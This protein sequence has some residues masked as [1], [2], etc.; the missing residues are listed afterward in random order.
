MSNTV[1]ENFVADFER[2]GSPAWLQ[3]GRDAALAAFRAGGFPTLRQE[4]WKYTDVRPIAGRSFRR[5][6]VPGS[7]DALVAAQRLGSDAARELVFVDGHCTTTEGQPPIPGARVQSLSRALAETPAF[8]EAHLARHADIRRNGFVALNT[9]L[10]GDGAVVHIADEATVEAPIHLLFASGAN[11]RSAV[12]AYPRNLIVLG[13]DARAT[14]IENYTGPDDSEYLTNAVTEIVLGPGAVLEHYRLQQEGTQGFHVGGTI[15]RQE[16]DSRYV[17][18]VMSLGAMLSRSD[19]DVQ[20]AGEGGT[21]VLNGLYVC[22]GRQHAD[23]HVRVDHLKPRT[24]SEETYR[25]VLDGSARAVFNGKVVVHKDA[26]KTDAR[27]SNANLLLSDTAEV[28]TK[29]ELEIYADDVK[30]SHGATVGRLDPDM[31]FY[32]RSRAIPE[33]VARDLLIYAFAEDLIRRLEVKPIR[34][35]IERVVTGRLPGVALL[36]EFMQ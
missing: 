4:D 20:L 11:A 19:L 14:V 8:L 24:I 34:A 17:S 22:G 9:A 2:T 35:R 3:A 36:S 33:A 5:A 27:Q 21:A 30:C 18:H 6:S 28:D 26:V 23:N 25:G 32:L 7:A 16:R 1:H 29:P 15:V 31:L 13:R 12:A 10:I